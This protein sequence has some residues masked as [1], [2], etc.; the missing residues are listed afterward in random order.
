MRKAYVFLFRV[1][2]AIAL[3]TN[4]VYAQEFKE[5]YE[6]HNV[7]L[8]QKTKET[9][10]ISFARNNPWEIRTT[11]LIHIS[12]FVV[13]QEKSTLSPYGWS[14][15]TTSD[16][17]DVYYYES[18]AEAPYNLNPGE[19]T[20]GFMYV[21]KKNTGIVI[22][23]WP[24]FLTVE[25]I[26]GL[27]WKSVST[28]YLPGNKI[29][30]RMRIYTRENYITPIMQQI[31]IYKPNVDPQSVPISKRGDEYFEELLTFKRQ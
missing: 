26:K 24:V 17:E 18:L 14:Q 2:V 19:S 5:T 22:E 11:R 3:I 23:A 30:K 12:K 20:Y 25:P 29:M 27:L 9:W 15:V 28:A 13:V 16:A 6:V 31:A 4:S 8:N 1:L 10:N 21:K 7:L